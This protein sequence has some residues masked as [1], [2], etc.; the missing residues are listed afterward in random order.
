MIAAPPPA[1]ARGVA[2]VLTELADE[3]E[4]LGG[5]LCAHPVFAAEHLSEL[6]AID[7]IAQKLG[8]LAG[9]LRADC[10]VTAISGVQLDALKNR[11]I[12]L[13]DELHSHMPS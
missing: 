3:I 11:F 2:E 9:V 7:L 8:S 13:A 5:T 1:V 10:A 12:H 4:R 6:Q